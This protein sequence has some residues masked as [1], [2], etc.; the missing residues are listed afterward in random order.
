VEEESDGWPVPDD[1]TLRDAAR[2]LEAHGFAGELWDRDWRLAYLTTEYRLLVSA[3]RYH[4]DVPGRGEFFL[5]PAMC[6]ARDAW[7]TGPTFE[8]LRDSLPE[9]GGFL[10]A[11]APV[12]REDLIEA[13]DPRLRAVLS[14][15]DPAPAP[16]LWSVRVDVRFG[17]E[18]IG[19][20]VLITRLHDGA[21]ARAGYS[22]VVKPEIRA[23]VLGMLALGDARLFERMS[24][25]LEPAR[26]PAAIVFADLEGSSALARRLSTAAYFKLI[27]RVASAADRA[28]VERGGIVGKHVGDGVTAFFLAENAPSESAAARAAIEG[29]SAIRAAAHRAAERC[30]LE[31]SEVTMR[32]GLH[33][34]STLYVGRLLTSGR[35]EVTALGDE[36]NEAARIEA[37]A[38]GGRALASKAL[39]ER[40]DNRDAE[41][42]GL[43]PAGLSYTPLAE[44]ST[45]GEKAR[46]DAPAIAVCEL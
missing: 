41:A 35:A 23:G 6:A 10:M 2:A 8:S 5:S 25:L 26:R 33:W 24:S 28:V 46:R 20:D 14:T 22:I 43:D 29:T 30:G 15:I 17:R 13:A 38:V 16:P 19:N 39:I 12:S 44:L 3:G 18:I 7:P 1:P 21:G 34:G 36:V 9:W 37:C 31:P 11:T 42:L 45:A 32:F 4:A 40:I 27:R